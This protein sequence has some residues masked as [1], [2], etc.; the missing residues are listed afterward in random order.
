MQKSKLLDLFKLL[1]T[2]EV[3]KLGIYLQSKA[4]KKTDI[5]FKLYKIIQKN[6]PDY[7]H[8]SLN[9][10]KVFKKLY[11]RQAYNDVNMRRQMS[12]LTKLLEDFLTFIHIEESD[13][14]KDFFLLE[15]YAKRYSKKH[16]KLQLEK[17]AKKLDKQVEK[18]LAFHYHQYILHEQAYQFDN[19][20][21]KPLFSNGLPTVV[22]KL[23]IYYLAN[24]LRYHCAILVEK[25]MFI[26]DYQAFLLNEI[27]AALSTDSYPKTP[28]IEGYYKLILLYL[29]SDENDFLSLKKILMQK[30]AS[31]S[32]FDLRQ[33]YV[34]A[35]NYCTW[36]IQK[37]LL[38]YYQHSFELYQT[39]IEQKLIFIGE[40]VSERSYTAI[41][42]IAL[43]LKKYDWT[44]E[45]IHDY[46][47]RLPPNQ[48]NW[49]NFSLAVWFFHQKD[50]QNVQLNLHNVTYAIPMVHILCKR[51]LL[52]TYYESRQ[53]DLFISLINAFNDLLRRS[54][55]APNSK[56]AYKNFIRYT[57]KLYKI[58]SEKIDRTQNLLLIEQEIKSLN[59]I[60]DQQWLLEKVEGVRD[61]QKSSK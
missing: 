13:F 33:L 1:N 42:N 4:I 46:G 45:F 29:K 18:D 31:T 25:N 9:K 6:A 56:Q 59:S 49:Y 48:K 7:A 5:I 38:N 12:T 28:T 52:K 44:K 3:N 54:K 8:P 41:V 51:L 35:L 50:Y 58:S 55:I 14:K 22:D 11:G 2:Q 20:L 24:V 60:V 23:N 34:G 61:F 43:V 36:Q 17:I 21:D 37:G 10:Q 26:Q 53:T 19:T 39:M 16:F 57:N 47:K 40:Y 15:E 32:N 30:N 27:L